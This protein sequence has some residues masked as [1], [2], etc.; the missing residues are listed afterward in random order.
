MPQFLYLIQPTRADML[1]A[2]PTAAEQAAVGAHFAYLQDN[3][4]RGIVR[5]AGRT[6]TTG[7]ETL[8]ICIFEAADFAAARAFTAADPA[9]AA[10]VFRAEL[11]PFRIAIEARAGAS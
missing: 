10:G 2:G 6:D 5:L 8:G 1:T 9:I 11:H 7:P 3:A 4:A